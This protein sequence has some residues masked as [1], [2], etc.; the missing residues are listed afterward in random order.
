LVP[1]LQ[2]FPMSVYETY[3]PVIGLEVHA[4]LQTKSK[5]YCS[6][7]T[8]YGAM[9][10]T[11]ISP[12]S[13]GHPG[14]LPFFNEKVLESA[15]KLGLACQSTIREENQFA[16]KNYFYADLPKG[17]QITQDKTPICNGGFVIIRDKEGKEKKIGITRIHMEEDAGKSIHDV[18]PF[19]TLVDINR[20]GVALVEIVSE[21]DLR[22]PEDA[23]AYLTEVRKLVRY[24]AI[25]DGNME[26]GS[27][28]CDANVSVRKIGSTKFGNRVEIKNMNSIRNVQR[29]IEGEIKRQIDLIEAGES[30]AQETHSFDAST[31]KTFVLRSKEMANDYRY[32]PEPDLLPVWVTESYLQEIKNSMP[33]LPR[34]LFLRYTSSLGLSEYDAG[35][36]TESREFALYFEKIIQNNVNPKA[37]TNFMMG[38]VKS[39]LNERA[40][41]ILE[42][43]IQ[44]KGIAD[45]LLMIEK[46]VITNNIAGQKI[47]PAMIENPL[48]SPSEIAEKNNWVTSDN[49]D[50]LNSFIALTLDKYPE[51]VAEYRNGKKGIAGL[52]MGEIMKL[53]KGK[54]DPK[55]ANEMLLKKLD[56]L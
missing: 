5:A 10:N 44:P 28:R 31:G 18:D 4:Q 35:V 19:H 55:K 26:E 17:Y 40:I 37:A 46:G 29:A 47:F 54:A 22:S 32:F 38:P 24:L 33:P 50:E 39:F 13:L 3:E 48:L 12:V 34:E 52:F 1:S 56:T 49:D 16:R 20:A 36:L 21:P 14:T 42:F 45:L 7:A 51:K 30:I 43:P 11:Q 53:S 6:D 2:E 15:I 27:L 41:D 8:E 9:P 23:Y 25:C